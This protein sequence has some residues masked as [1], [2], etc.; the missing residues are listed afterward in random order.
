ML[1]RQRTRHRLRVE[2]RSTRTI[3]CGLEALETRQLLAAATGPVINEFLASNLSTSFLDDYGT[4]QD[5]IEVYNPTT[6]AIDLSNWHLTDSKGNPAKST[7][8][9]GTSLAAGGYLV[10]FADGRVPVSGTTMVTGPGG[11]LHTNFSLDT[12]GEYLALTRGDNSVA[13]SYDPFPGQQSNISY[14]L[15]APTV[16][17]NFTLLGSGPTGG[18]AQILV[19]T[20]A[21]DLPADWNSWDFDDTAWPITGQSGI[22][23]DSDSGPSSY[24]SIL[25]TDLSAQM[26]GAGKN[27]S[28]FARMEFDVTGLVTD[29]QSLKLRMRYDDG[30]V[31]YLNGTK[32]V[33]ANAPG[34]PVWNSTATGTVAKNSGFVEFDVTQYLSALRAGKNV[35]AIQ[36]LND[37]ATS[38]DFLVMPE[39]VGR[40]VTFGPEQYMTTPT[41]GAQNAP[42]AL[43]KVNDTEFSVDRGFFTSPFQLRIG[44]DTAGATIRYTTDGSLPTETSGTIY[45]GPIT[46]DHTMT[47]RAIAYKAGFI[48]T[49]VDAQTYIFPD[50]VIHQTGAALPPAYN[51]GHA[52]PDWAMDPDIVNGH[53]QEVIAGLKSV[54]SIS[55]ST[56]WNE[57]FNP[58]GSGL[59]V[60]NNNRVDHPTSFEFIQPNGTAGVHSTAAVQLQG[61]SSDISWRNDKLSLDVKF[62]EAFGNSKLDYD[63]FGAGSGGTKNFDHLILD[64][65]FNGG[66]TY[67][68]GVSPLNQRGDARYIQDQFVSDMV[69]AA[70]GISP[71][72]RYVNLYLDGLYWGMYYLHEK[73]DEAFA[74]AYEGGEKEDYDVLKHT[75][76]TVVAGSTTNYNALLTAVRQDMSIPANYQAVLN[77]LDIVDFVDYMIVNFYAG[78]TDWAHQ[79]W[80]AS[81]NRN[82]PNGKW[83]YHSWDAEH[84][85]VGTDESIANALSTNVVGK[86]D[87]G[88]PTEINTRLRANAEYRTLFADEV[89]RLL[90]NPGGLF[91]PTGIAAMWQGRVNE[92]DAAMLSE[93]ARW[94]D[95]INASTPYTRDGWRADMT[96]LLTNYFP[97]RGNTLIT[98]LKNVST[99]QPL[100]PRTTN[101][102]TF[103]TYGGT[104]ASATSVTISKPAGQ[105]G[106]IYYTIDGSDPRLAT[107]LINPAA[108]SIAS[109][110]NVS[111]PTSRRIKARILNGTE[112]SALVNP[113][114]IIG[115]A[116][117]LRVSEIMYHPAPPPAGS[118]YTADDFE[119]IELRNTGATA[120]NPSGFTFTDGITFT[121]PAG[122]PSIAAGARVLLV[123]NP[124]AF[125]TRYP[126]VAVAG[127]FTGELGDDGE[128]LT[129]MTD[130]GQSIT[131]FAYSDGW[132]GATDGDGYS[133]TAIDP[134]ATD[135]V[136][137]TKLGW[138]ASQ[139]SNGTPGTGADDTFN[140]L[141]ADVVVINEVM[142]FATGP[143]ATNWIELRNTS[144]STPINISGWWLSD[145][146]TNRQKWQIPAGTILS[147]NGYVSFSQSG[148]F[149]SVF[150]LSSLGDDIYLTS[151]DGAGGQGGYRDHVDF[152]AAEPNVS[153]GRYV[154]STGT[155]DFPALAVPT[156]N[157]ANADPKVGPV[158]IN[159]IMYNPG[160][161]GSAIEYVEIRNITDA[162][163][164]L[165]G[166]QFSDGVGFTFGAGDTIAGNA[167]ALVVPIDPATF[168]STYGIPSEVAVFG[169]YTGQL[170]NGG[171]KLTL[172]KPGTPVGS[173]VPLV[174]VD[175]VNYDN[176]APWPAPPA[177]AGPSL[178]RVNAVKYGNDPINWRPDAAT[179]TAGA[180]NSNPPLVF[181]DS[182]AYDG[183]PTIRAKFSK[184]VGASLGAQS[185]SLLNVTT[186][187]SVPAVQL[188][189]SYDGATQTATW[190]LP[191]TLADGN[192]R[193]TLVATAIA[194]AQGGQL[195]GNGDGTG[196]DDATLDFFH[197][198]GDAN[199]D[200]TVDFNDLVKLAQNYNSNS[201][202]TFR[203]G[204]FN[205]DAN[206]DFNDLVILAQH[207]NSSLPA[208]GAAVSASP[209][210]ATSLA[211]ALGLASPVIQPVT[212]SAS[213][214][215]AAPTK[216]APAHKPAPAKKTIAPARPV[217]NVVT[218]P[219]ATA[220]F[221]KK[222]VTDSLFG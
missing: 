25:Q 216:P 34:S 19:P 7:F 210:S 109:S 189:M 118:P 78:N 157:A 165:A 168:R 218:R 153:F 94:G 211:T 166:W 181:L 57:F 184:D 119:Y 158:V 84:T 122:S 96:T 91:T 98:Q 161:A 82:D 23:Y 60:S 172:S 196:G 169:P 155:I 5:W 90:L 110:A 221:G 176:E 198:G 219:A 6:S 69:N 130:L 127:T 188:T 194:D 213:P 41:P 106:T 63:I 141:T 9:A 48:S 101:A 138:R 10:V 142:S 79:N 187:Q 124:T 162:P 103:S 204:D 135:A 99:T 205:F 151:N 174:T 145:D 202:L 50:Q 14:G 200:R 74:A 31:A 40:R 4:R 186:G 1:N 100:Y 171:E 35:L 193:A 16:Q 52:G 59:Y 114:F 209:V 105:A 17:G 86:N 38:P 201:S 177:G 156:R 148:D 144:Q 49:N 146:A 8:P 56:N 11:K 125:A 68:G 73:P 87:T 37:S 54:P 29:F 2:R 179:G 123:R 33:S 18:V 21:S 139:P 112:W 180:A 212:S 190:Q 134:A 128:T 121:F 183:L 154:K 113:A 36:G 185:L 195:D 80:Y 159:E 163:V 46:I 58:D 126:G 42:G 111:I 191:A 75:S 62:Q 67:N 88:G 65:V 167:Y 104:F 27:T 206:V 32:I 64:A 164:S 207:Y 24:G 53:E 192:Y 28:A 81:F 147:G 26:S 93:S 173:V 129:F 137:S 208:A 120:I 45:T 47:V 89:Q 22:G 143:G 131:S 39:L 178:G 102:P 55:L 72:G 20:Q 117:A 152:G 77:K 3:V 115:G 203:D 13:S 116:P 133:L 44:S 83:R 97:N 70:G 43:G 15:G 222:R 149:G 51:W 71:H 182:F 136:L 170:N 214:G 217:V 85:F 92:V 66:W 140:N 30:F 12:D 132:Y 150:A 76:S 220:T 197:L 108:T 215:K 61:G 199:H 107:G 95:N 175:R 160:P